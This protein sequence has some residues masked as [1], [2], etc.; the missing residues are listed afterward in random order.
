MILNE[1]DVAKATAQVCDI[2]K[3]W[4]P[5]EWER[6]PEAKRQAIM[7]WVAALE[8]MVLEKVLENYKREFNSALRG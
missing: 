8:E 3:K 2:S 7:K 6:Q 4:S 1:N 5:L